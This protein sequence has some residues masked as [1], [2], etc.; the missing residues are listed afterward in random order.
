[1]TERTQEIRL[2]RGL[3]SADKFFKS[4]EWVAEDQGWRMRTS[5]Q[6]LAL[7]LFGKYLEDLDRHETETVETIQ[8]AMVTSALKA[9]LSVAID[10]D[11]LRLKTVREWQ[12]KAEKNKILLEVVDVE[13]EVVT[14]V[15]RDLYDRFFVKGKFPT[16]PPFEVQE[17]ERGTWTKYEP[18]EEL[19]KAYIFDIDGTLAKMLGRSPFDWARVGEDSPI[20]DVIRV[21]QALVK[22][23]YKIIFMSGRDE[24]CF[25]ESWEWLLKHELFGEALFMRPANSYIPDD[26]VKHDLFYKHVAPN[27]NVVGVFD[28]RLKVCRMWEEI[29][30]TLFRVGPIDSDF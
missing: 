30:L 26:V 21:A 14:E 18:N 7:Q 23:G 2:F 8:H 13:T 24:V 17:E 4:S 1:M 10:D 28:D 3:P 6:D 12:S 15:Q 5:R 11:N 20:W 27:Y 22:T 19:E 16:I 9:N 29:G 25:D